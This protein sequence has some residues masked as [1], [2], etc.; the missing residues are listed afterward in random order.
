MESIILQKSSVRQVSYGGSGMYMFQPKMAHKPMTK[1]E[2]REKDT[3]FKKRLEEAE[4]RLAG[5]IA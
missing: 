4:K 2:Q 1:K 5:E 3:A